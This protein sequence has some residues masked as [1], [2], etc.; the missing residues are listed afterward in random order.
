MRQARMVLLV[1]GHPRKSEDVISILPI[2]TCSELEFSQ[3]CVVTDTLPEG[4]FT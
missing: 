3:G 4:R 1:A 2:L